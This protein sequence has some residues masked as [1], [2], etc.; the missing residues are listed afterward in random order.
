MPSGWGVLGLNKA[1]KFL[2]SYLFY[3]NSGGIINNVSDGISNNVAGGFGVKA[4]YNFSYY[5]FY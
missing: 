1:V 2:Y 3:I 5:V 4:I